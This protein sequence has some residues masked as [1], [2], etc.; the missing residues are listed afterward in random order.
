MLSRL[1]YVSRLADAVDGHETR[2]IL[3]SSLTNNPRRCVTGALVFNSGHFIQWLEG[4]RSEISRLFAHI[5]KDPRHTHV[6]LIDFESIAH[7]QFPD[8]SMGYI[9]E[10]VLN[11]ALFARYSQ[12]FDFNPYELSSASAVEFVREAA[13]VGLRLSAA[14]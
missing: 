2:R 4:S 10:G 6:E 14:A 8:W 5:A 3:A 1:I 11:K 12:G 13:L 7:R 9:G